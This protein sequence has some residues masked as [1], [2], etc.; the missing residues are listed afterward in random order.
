MSNIVNIPESALS[1]L[2][3]FFTD[4]RCPH[5]V[6]I[7][8]AGELQ[9]AELA[10][11]TSKMI[12]CSNKER[13]P[14]G[15]CENCR[16]ADESIHPDIIT[17]KK[18]DDKKFFVKADVKKVVGD[19]YLTPNEADKKVYILSEI[20]NMNEESQNLLLKILEEPPAYTAFVLTSQNANA[21]IGTVLSRVVRLRLG[22]TEDAEYSEKAIEAVKALSAAVSSPYEFE[23]VK[24][25]AVLEGNKALTAEV[26]SLFIGV[27]RDAIALK[28]QGA[29]LI[30]GMVAESKALS[31]KHTLKKLLDMYDSVS[32]IYQSLENN[33]NYTLLNAVLCA[34]LG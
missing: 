20:Q 21:V 4:G 28:S 33:P 15:A 24:A 13:T 7:D 5:A 12:V 32:G 17:V 2:D 8:G 1:A 25:T 22:K 23:K 29:P 14:C 16:K 26:L 34:R 10:R 9:R 3:S 30:E 11:L 6:L 19:A 31:E 27:L 18:P